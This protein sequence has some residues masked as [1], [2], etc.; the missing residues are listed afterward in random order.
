MKKIDIKFT[1]IKYNLMNGLLFFIAQVVRLKSPTATLQRYEFKFFVGLVISFLL[2]YL[3]FE[4]IFKNE[5][6]RE[7]APTGTGSSHSSSETPRN[8]QIT[9]LLRMPGN[10]QGALLL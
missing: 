4:V 10:A 1:I 9:L 3:S 6:I 7:R 8:P 2:V 5:L